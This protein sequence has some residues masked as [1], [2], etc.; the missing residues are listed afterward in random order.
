MPY[1]PP[2]PAALFDLGE[3]LERVTDGIV[4]CDG[5]LRVAYANAAAGR[6]LAMR[7]PDLVGRMLLEVYPHLRGAFEH[8]LREVA[9]RGAPAVLEDRHPGSGHAFRHTVCRTRDGGVVT[10]FRDVTARRSAESALSRSLERYRT[11]FESID[12]GFCVIEVLFDETGAS[13]DYRFLEVNPSFERQTGLR[14][15][16]GR[17]MRELAPA[18]EAHWFRIYGEVATSGVPVRFEERAEALHRWYDVY[19]FRVDDP[20]QHRVAVLFN[21]VTQRKRVEQ[22]LQEADRHKDEFLAILAHELRNPLAPLRNGLEIMRLAAGPQRAQVVEQS[23]AMMQ[24]QVDHLVALVDDLLD[25]S[26]I[27]RGLITID[28]RRVDLSEIA[29]RALEAAEPMVREREH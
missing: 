2:S 4:A 8:A 22:A 10:Y 29:H 24:R 16:V 26:R 11:L 9:R 20:Q 3:V 25:V 13:H 17:R 19:A 1:I 5:D 21:D 23:R 28:R 18:H 7:P 15:A 14:D 6:L 27:S 12:E